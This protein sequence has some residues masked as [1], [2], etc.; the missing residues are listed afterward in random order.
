MLMALSDE[1][2]KNFF[3]KTK[4]PFVAPDS[5][6]E[7]S[8]FLPITRYRV[9]D[10]PGEKTADLN[11]KKLGQT[12]DKPRTKHK[13]NLGQSQDKPKTNLGQGKSIL[14]E[15]SDKPRTQPRTNVRTNLG[16]TQ[17]NLSTLSTFSSLVGLQRKI[18]LYIY[19]VCKTSRSRITSPVSMEHLA[20]ACQTTK[21]SVQKT[22]QRLENKKIIVRNS[23]KNG[24]GGWT[25]YELSDAIYQEI[26]QEET[27]S[28]LRTNLGQTQDK[29]RSEPRTELRTSLPSSSS[30]YIINNNNTTTTGETEESKNLTGDWQTICIDSLNDIGFTTTHLV[31]IAQQ[32]KLSAEIVQDSIEAFA[33]DLK[34]NQKAKHVKGSPLNYFMGIVRNGQPY[35]PPGNYE[36][37]QDREMRIYLERK[38]KIDKARVEREEELMKLAF[39]EWER[40][41][42]EEYKQSL[43]PEDVR[44]NRLSGPKQ[45]TLRAYFAREIWPQKRRELQDFFKE[46]SLLNKNGVN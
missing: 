24:R 3:D 45:A 38:Q 9:F 4:K 21:L 42:S 5:A 37:P 41:Q 40:E 12:Q 33:F 13:T 6:K 17:D 11:I 20:N 22:V 32:K 23:F 34:Y 14:L 7:N 35:A 46:E 8:Q 15:T 29:L 25:Q 28:K 2:L 30:S 44:N 1:V 43:L 39:D 10:E 16:Q 19:E 31:Q 26:I 18:T 27:Q 36:S